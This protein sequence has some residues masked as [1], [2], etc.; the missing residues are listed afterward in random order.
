ML[1]ALAATSFIREPRSLSCE[2]AV[3]PACEAEMGDK[4]SV[5]VA[6]FR[7]FKVTNNDT[8]PGKPLVNV[9][10]AYFEKD[11]SVARMGAALLQ[12]MASR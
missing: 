6:L 5:R 7:Q 10:K 12:H 4:S 11:K 3:Y 9:W 1:L 8:T 2:P